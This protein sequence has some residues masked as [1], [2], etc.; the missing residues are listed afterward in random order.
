MLWKDIISISNSPWEPPIVLVRKM[1]C[2]GFVYPLPQIDDTLDTLRGS[3]LFTTLDL[4][5][6]YWHVEV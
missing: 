4:V 5:S 1:E 3:N 2:F 6:G